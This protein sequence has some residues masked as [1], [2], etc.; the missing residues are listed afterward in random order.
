MIGDINR[1]APGIEIDCS[2]PTERVIRALEQIIEWRGKP[3]AIRC[4]SGPENI[5]GAVQGGGE[6]ANPD[7]LHPARQAAAKYLRRAIQSRRALRVAIPVRRGKSRGHAVVRN[8]MDVRLQSCAP[9]HGLKRLRTKTAVG[10]G[11]VTP[12]LDALNSGGIATANNWQQ[13]DSPHKKNE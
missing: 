1:E 11:R 10:H 13:N 5:S 8:A 3:A 6:A 7:R 12:L 4:D 9:T 2:T